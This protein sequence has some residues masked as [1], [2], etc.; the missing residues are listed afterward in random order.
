MM[1]H[2]NKDLVS[3]PLRG[4]C[5]DNLVETGAQRIRDYLRAQGAAAR[6]AKALR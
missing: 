3:S 4:H 2:I 1:W 5:Y 6:E